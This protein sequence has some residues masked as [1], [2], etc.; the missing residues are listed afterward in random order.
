MK[1]LLIKVGKAI[2]VLKREGIFS[3]GKRVF[4]AF[5]ALFR[6]VGKGQILFVTGGVGDSARYRTGHV[7]EEL[8]LNGFKCSI[9]VQD[10]PWLISYVDKFEIFVFHRVLYTPKVK[11]LLEKIKA[12]GKE[13]IFE[14]DDLV[15]DAKYLEHMD[16][17]KVMNSFEKKLYENGVGGE[18]LADPAVK[19]CT[20]TT[21][22]L[23]EKLREHNKEVFIVPNRLSK[24]DV[25][26]AE[27]ILK[28][29][30]LMPEKLQAVKIGY[31]SGALSHNKDFATITEVL[32]LLMEKHENLELFLVGPLD[33][34][35][36]LQKFA[37]RIKQ[38]PYTAREK[39]FANV[40]SVDIN[41]APL[42][43]GNPFCESK[44]ELKF[45]EAGI[46]GVPTVATATQ[47]FFDAI[48]DGEDGFVANDTEQWTLKLEKLISDKDL[49][50]AMGKKAREKSLERYTTANAS[51]VEYY[52]YLKSKLKNL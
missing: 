6:F 20:T 52:G 50:A 7:S 48:S 24:K 33:I 16:Y 9:T 38:F 34:E 44:S 17:F 22:F 13:I 11:E 27:A 35:S 43:I 1:L 41:I 18:I 36:K 29:K 51:N 10:N 49:R 47:P 19:V 3:G 30:K 4:S 5:F 46:V 12:A 40:A 28:A 37:D 32:M 25:E 2:E 15:Y 14:T 45:F 42:E 39:H 8:E 23:A 26:I 21:K 31:F